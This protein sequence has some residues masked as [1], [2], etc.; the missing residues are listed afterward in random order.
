MQ[1]QQQEH[2]AGYIAVIGRPNAAKTTH[3]DKLIG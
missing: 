2:R 3:M 1:V